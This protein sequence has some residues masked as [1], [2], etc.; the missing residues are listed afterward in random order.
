MPRPG[1]R[2]AHRF[3]LPPSAIRLA[4]GCLLVLGCGGADDSPTDPGDPPPPVPPPPADSV[5]LATGRLSLPAATTIGSSGYH[6]AFAITHRLS[7]DIVATA[8]QLLELELRDLTR[9]AQLCTSSEP[10]DGCAAID[11]SDDP[12]QPGVPADGR[13]VNRMIVQLTTGPRELHLTRGQQ[14][15][16]VP[17]LVDPTQE[18]TAIGGNGVVWETVLPADVVGATDLEMRLVLTKWLD[19]SVE[20]G[21]EVRASS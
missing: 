12:R 7:A 13:F 9:P 19:P 11:W 10:E 1:R 20:I 2:P 8:G 15:S 5:V 16:E 3:R 17:D 14:L 21:Y 18:H 6:E 4:L